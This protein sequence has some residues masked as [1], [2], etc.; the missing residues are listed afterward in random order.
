MGG[1]GGCTTEPLA[2]ML[3]R[4][5]KYTN[6]GVFLTLRKQPIRHPVRCF[7]LLQWTSIG[8]LLGSETRQTKQEGQGGGI[9]Y[10]ALERGMEA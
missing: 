6:V 1:S 3:R 9:R 8:W 4:Q 2:N 7:P 10:D 5:I